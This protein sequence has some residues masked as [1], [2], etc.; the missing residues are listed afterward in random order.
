MSSRFSNPSNDVGACRHV[1]HMTVSAPELLIGDVTVLSEPEGFGAFADRISIEIGGAERAW[2]CNE[3]RPFDPPHALIIARDIVN[4]GIDS[5]YDVLSR[6]SNRID[7]FLFAARLLTGGTVNTMC[8]VLGPKSSLA[9]LSPSLRLAQG[10]YLA[11]PTLLR[12]PVR[13]TPDDA[14][15]LARLRRFDRSGASGPCRQDRDV[16]RRGLQKVQHHAI[17]KGSRMIRLPFPFVSA[18]LHVHSQMVGGPRRTRT[19]DILVV[20]EAL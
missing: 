8:K 6:T 16:A 3:P 12:R 20:S 19:T 9:P 18:D 11:M 2:H 14:S 7:R 17:N 4:V 5:P 13:L 10:R 15:K 1:A